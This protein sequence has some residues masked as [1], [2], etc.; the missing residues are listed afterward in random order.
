MDIE[1]MR[2]VEAI[3]LKPLQARPVDRNGHWPCPFCGQTKPTDGSYSARVRNRTGPEYERWVR[4]CAG[5]VTTI[6]R[7]VTS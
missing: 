2:D 5:C 1:T 6:P 4:A 7:A 3:E